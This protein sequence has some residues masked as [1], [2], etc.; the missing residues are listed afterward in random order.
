MSFVRVGF[1]SFFFFQLTFYMYLKTVPFIVHRRIL[2]QISNKYQFVIIIRI[3]ITSVPTLR[4]NF[5]IFENGETASLGKRSK[6]R[7]SLDPGDE[8]YNK[9]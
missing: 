7:R 4:I 3:I 1:F 6:A 8:R 2:V 5:R 9:R